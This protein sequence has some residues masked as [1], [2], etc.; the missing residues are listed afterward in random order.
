MKRNLVN[1]WDLAADINILLKTK[2][3]VLKCLRRYT[4][5]VTNL[6]GKSKNATDD[7]EA[8]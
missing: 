8:S 6:L 5:R 2:G 7:K 1:C 4:I 3:M